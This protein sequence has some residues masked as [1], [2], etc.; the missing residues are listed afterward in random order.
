MNTP[1]ERQSW[2]LKRIQ[3]NPNETFGNC[4]TEYGL[5]YKLSKQTFNSD[6]K[7]A[8]NK[9]L[10][11]RKDVEKKRTE[12]LTDLEINDGKDSVLTL[13]EAQKILTKIARGEV[14]EIDEEK[15]IPAHKDRITAISELGKMLR[16]QEIAPY[17]KVENMQVNNNILMENIGVSEKFFG[18]FVISVADREKPKQ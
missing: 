9:Y 5:I 14:E 3:K 8:S 7:K 15:I 12:A 1:K 16:W 17:M 6:W 4:F 13:L 10:E 2:I 11:Q 18:N